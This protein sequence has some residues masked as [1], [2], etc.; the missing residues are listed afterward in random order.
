M[1]APGFVQVLVGV[2]RGLMLGV[3]NYRGRLI[4]LNPVNLQSHV[5]T[6]VLWVPPCL[7]PLRQHP[8]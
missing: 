3:I 8:S 7:R 4:F 1:L 2:N 5:I 6:R